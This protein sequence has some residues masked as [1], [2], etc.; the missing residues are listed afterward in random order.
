R[1]R[2]R[3]V[4]ERPRLY[5]SRPPRASR[6]GHIGTSGDTHWSQVL[7]ALLMP[8]RGYL[9]ALPSTPSTRTCSG[10]SPPDVPWLLHLFERRYDRPRPGLPTEL[11]VGRHRPLERH[12]LHVRV[13]LWPVLEACQDLP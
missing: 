9:N 2:K 6:R 4:L 1:V 11:G 13:P 8:G 7:I 3:I 10:Y 5:P 12:R